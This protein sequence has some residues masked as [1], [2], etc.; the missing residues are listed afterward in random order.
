MRYLLEPERNLA[1]SPSLLSRHTPDF[2][3]NVAATVRRFLGNRDYSSCVPATRPGSVKSSQ[4][5]GESAYGG[6]AEKAKEK[7][8]ILLQHLEDVSWRVLGITRQL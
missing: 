1:I 3:E 2:R 7:S 5:Y 6:G 8:G 4:G